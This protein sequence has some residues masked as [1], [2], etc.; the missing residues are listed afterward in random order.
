M[1]ISKASPYSDNGFAAPKNEFA[2]SCHKPK[3]EY[4]YTINMAYNMWYMGKIHHII[5]MKTTSFFLLL[6]TNLCLVASAYAQAQKTATDGDWTQQNVVLKNTSQADVMIRVGDIDNLNFTFAE[7][8]DPFCGRSTEPHFFPWQIDAKDIKGTDCI[9][10]SSSF[11]VK[12]DKG[13]GGDGYAGSHD[14]PSESM[15]P[16]PINIPLDAVKGLEIKSAMLQLFIDDFQSPALCSKFQMTL[17]G[18]RFADAEALLNT[19]DQSGPIGKLISVPLTDAF[20][21]LLQSDKLAILI[22]DPTT[23]TGDGYAIDFIKLL[24]NYKES[25]FCKGTGAGRVWDA[26]TGSPIANAN[27]ELRGIGTV[28][29]NEDGYFEFKGLVAGIHPVTA[30]A[31]GYDSGNGTLDVASSD[32]IQEINIYL[33]K[34]SKQATFGGKTLREGETFVISNIQF[35]QSSDVLKTEGKSELDKI[36]TF[37]KDNPNAQIELSGHTS[38]EG[39]ANTNKKLSLRR[40]ESCKTYLTQKGVDAGRILTVGYGPDKPIASNDSETNRAK[41]RRVE[42]RVL[43]L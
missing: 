7:G 12:E 39:D 14:N 6:G 16:V 23:G 36:V 20:L 33:N 37:M 8:F 34:G 13:C 19:V 11:R 1:D 15:R 29:T 28:K 21:P 38:S 2:Q 22:D 25:G 18:K 5:I 4:L 31:T 32:D 41:N 3:G 30:F 43:K 27:V 10:T 42:M 35:D 17:N 26:E 40:V 9:Y 24:V